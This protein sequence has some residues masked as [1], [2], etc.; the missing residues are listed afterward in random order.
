M[1][2][3]LAAIVGALLGALAA[4]RRRGNPF[5]IAQ[6]AA[7]WGIVGGLVGFVVLIVLTRL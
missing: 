1:L 5:D 7:V 4:R 3:I 6:W 2:P